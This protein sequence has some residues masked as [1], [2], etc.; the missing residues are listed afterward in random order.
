MLSPET[1]KRV[2]LLFK[3]EEWE[4]VATLLDEQC[5][6]NLPFLEEFDEYQLERVRFAALKIS[7]GSFPKLMGA[8]ELAQSDWRDL[9]MAAEFGYDIHAHEAWL[10]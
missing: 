7:N 1:W 9:L 4:Q 6:N 3:A 2:N 10:S 8:F 5:G